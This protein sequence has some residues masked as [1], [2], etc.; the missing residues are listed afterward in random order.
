MLLALT[1]CGGQESAETAAPEET[2]APTAAPTPEPT[3][4]PTQEPTPFPEPALQADCP[5]TMDGNELPSGSFLHEGLRYVYLSEAAQALG[6]EPEKSEDGLRCAFPWRKSRVELQADGAALTYREESVPLE[7]PV[8]LCKGGEELLLPVESFCEAIQIGL[9]YD[10]EYDHL[11]CTPA[12][13]NWELPQGYYVPVMMYHG[14]ASGDPNANLFVD[15][16]DMEEQIVYILENGYTPI[17]FSDLEHVEDYEKPVLLTFDDGWKNTYYYLLPLVEKYQVKVTT[18][19]ICDALEQSGNHLD[20]DQALEMAASGYVDFQSHTMTHQILTQLKSEEQEYELRESRLFLTR[21]FGKEPFVLAYPSGGSNAKVQELTS[22][23]YRFG[24]KMY[25]GKPYIMPY[26]TSD[27]PMLVYRFFPEKQT[28]LETY[29][30]WLASAFPPEGQPV[31]PV[32][33][34][35]IDRS[36]PAATTIP[37]PTPEPPPTPAPTPEPDPEPVPEPDP[38]P[39][40]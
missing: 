35:W 29:A 11:Y 30:S 16:R 28:M 32:H 23:Y 4:E 22:R 1:A 2:A 25:E 37:L 12:A 5:V 18:F 13:G 38:A 15:P 24:V 26:N 9:L 14:V 34:R 8:L 33:Y 40:E 31:K 20:V 17:W 27:D 10:E 3:P 7:A 36:Q 39:G 19:M 6:L 21:M